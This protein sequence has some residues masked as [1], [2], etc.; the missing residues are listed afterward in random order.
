MR[1]DQSTIAA[2]RQLYSDSDLT[3]GQ[4]NRDRIMR[5]EWDGGT[6]LG[7]YIALAKIE[8]QEAKET[9]VDVQAKAA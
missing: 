2:A 7:I 6:W 3:R 4:L 8:A 9:A 5:G 1:E